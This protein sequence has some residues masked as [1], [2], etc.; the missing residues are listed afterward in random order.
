MRRYEEAAARWHEA[1]PAPPLTAEQREAL[2]LLG[3]A[4]KDH[5]EPDLGG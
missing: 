3:Q 4:M 5:P 1:H 2:A